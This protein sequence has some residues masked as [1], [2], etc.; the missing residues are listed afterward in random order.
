[1]FLWPEKQTGMKRNENKSEDKKTS[2]RLY[3]NA[4]NHTIGWTFFLMPSLCLLAIMV[5]QIVPRPKQEPLI[6][7]SKPA[8]EAVGTGYG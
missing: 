2:E 7:V 8:T 6:K 5:L 1:M 4:L 3:G